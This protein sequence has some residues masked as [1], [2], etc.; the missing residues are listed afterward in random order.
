MKVEVN[1]SVM[2]SDQKIKDESGDERQ[3]K[4]KLKTRFSVKRELDDDS[5]DQVASVTKSIAQEITTKRRRTRR[6]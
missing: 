5:L 6:G 3:T 2:S 4:T 1:E